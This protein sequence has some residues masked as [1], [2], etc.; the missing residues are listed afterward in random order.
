MY[1]RSIVTASL[2]SA[3]VLTFAAEPTHVVYE[4]ESGI[5]FGKHIVYIASDHEYR[6]EESLPALARIMAKRYGFK[7]TVVFGTDPATGEIVPGSSTIHGLH[8]L[9]DADLMVVFMRFIDM[10]DEEMQH[11][12]DYVDRGGPIMGLRTST[13]AFKIAPERKFHKYD[14]AYAGEDYSK[15][16]GRQVLG[17]TWVTHYGEN[18]K[19]SSNLV[20]EAE[21]KDH[22]ILRGVMDMHTMAGCYSANPIEGST[23]LAKATVLNGMESTSP[24]DPSKERMPVVWVREY[25]SKSF[26][27][28]RVFTTTQGASEDIL[29][30]GFRRLL[31]NAHLWC[32]GMENEIKPTNAIEFVG[33]YHPVTYSFKEFRRGIR[34]ADLAGWDS[35]ILNPNAPLTEK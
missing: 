23:V 33:P 30:A 2:M 13:H 27:V 7:C 10:P 21:A 8:V 5:G 22:S 20:I 24:P 12:V 18:H 3:A 25:K 34:P 15:G 19:Q 14:Y 1:A 31:V 9:K 32:L 17:E 11:F 6:S 28:A 16:F 4:G 29:N 35:P 26:K